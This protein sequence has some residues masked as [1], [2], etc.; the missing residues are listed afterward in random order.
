MLDFGKDQELGV[1]DLSMPND[2][3]CISRSAE[4][5]VAAA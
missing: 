4:E 2:F 1:V 3:D 5:T